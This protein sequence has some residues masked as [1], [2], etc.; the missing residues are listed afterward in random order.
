MIIL[1][2]DV[3]KIDKAHI[4]E[5]KKGKYIEIVVMENRDGE[6]AYGN[7]HMAVQGLPKEL[8]DQGKKGP[9]LG[10]GKTFGQSRGSQQQRTKPMSPGPQQ[11]YT[12]P[13]PQD[14]EIPW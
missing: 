9:I 6:D 11:G 8:R 13:P 7:T 1:K 10:N 12:M 14:D 2:I 5:G 3:T 4:Y